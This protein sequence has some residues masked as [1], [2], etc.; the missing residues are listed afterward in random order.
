MYKFYTCAQVSE[1]LNVNKELVWKWIRD[2]KLTALNFG[3]EYRIRE[4]DLKAFIESKVQ[5]SQ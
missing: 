4:E 1:I 5:Q 3:R 2:R